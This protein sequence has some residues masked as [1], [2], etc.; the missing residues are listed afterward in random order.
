MATLSGK[1]P[2]GDRNG[3]A[4]LE[5]QFVQ[6]PTRP[7]VLLVVVDTQKVVRNVDTG[8][9]EP[10]LRILRIEQVLPHDASTAERLVRR[11]LEHRN[12]ADALPIELD[13]E[14]T[15]IFREASID[16]KGEMHYPDPEP[17]SEPESDEEQ[18]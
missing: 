4:D 2:K 13:D 16:D 5:A 12:G 1:L 14:I 8:D 9:T 11:A 7:H 18:A 15:Q 6:D 3:I 17:K 10:S